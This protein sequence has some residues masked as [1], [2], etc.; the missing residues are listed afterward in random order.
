MKKNYR[1]LATLAVLPLLPACTTLKY[2]AQEKVA[3]TPGMAAITLKDNQVQ[4]PV[5]VEGS[6]RLMNIDLGASRSVLYDTTCISGYSSR[7]KGHFGLAKGGTGGHVSINQVPL[8]VASALHTSS[9]KVFLVLP[10]TPFS[11]SFNCSNVS[12]AAGLY[13]YDFFSEDGNGS[14]FFNFSNKEIG[15]ISGQ[16]TDSLVAAGYRPVKAKLSWRRITIYI[17]INGK[18]YPFTLDTGFDG[19]FVIPAHKNIVFRDEPHVSLEGL[20]GLTVS[21]VSTGTDSY[22][23]NKNVTFG[24]SEY[25][26]SISVSETIKLQNA[27]MGFI[28]GFNWIFDFKHKKV[29]VKENGIAMDKGLRK[30]HDFYA[31]AKD[32]KLFV[33]LRTTGSTAY[34]IGDR[35]ISVNDTAVTETNICYLLQQLNQ[36]PDWKALN[37]V[38]SKAS[39]SP[40]SLK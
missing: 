12:S 20:Q 26:T 4:L 35:I 22:Y 40:L 37:V 13:G 10:N 8:Q 28:K 33:R 15:K 2:A 38:T 24:G 17:T 9:N 14:Y 6:E 21:G 36:S 18:E 39:G 3:G 34:A 31:Y 32:N 7:R 30:K 1:F 23:D 19:T 5:K 16:Q 29:Y 25:A 27:G 11:Q